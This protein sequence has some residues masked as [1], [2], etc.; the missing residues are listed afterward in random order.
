[1][2]IRCTPNHSVL[3]IDN[4]AV[5]AL[6]NY[7]GQMVT[8]PPVDTVVLAIHRQADDSLYHQLKAERA[9]AESLLLQVREVDEELSLIHI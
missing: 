4:G 7:S 3:S 2:G 6:H 9:R 1:M 5:T 8:F